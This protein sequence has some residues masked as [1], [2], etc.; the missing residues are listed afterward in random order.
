MYK[1]SPVF[2][3]PENENATIWRYMDFTKF[4]SLLDKSAP[5]FTRADRLGDPFEGSYSKANVV[6]RPEVYKGKIPEGTLITLSQFHRILIRHTV[7]NCWHLSEY[8]SAAMWKLYLKSD[9]G[10]AVRSTFRRLK[11]C[12]KGDKFHIYIGKVKYIDYDKDW[13]PEGNALYPFVHK[14]KSFE[15]EQELRAV[16]QQFR[17]T[18]NGEINW[19]RPLFDDGVYVQVDL[20]LLIDKIY[21]APTAP[22]WLPELVKSVTKRYKLDKE[23]VQSTLDDVP[24]Y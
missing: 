21:L 12:F 4:V 1:E 14:R 18:K 8:E 6:R 24:V 2:E 11:D 9:E 3:K 22:K 20:D 19:D 23:V 10:I 15:H 5:F 16:I 7:I 17:Y 13:L